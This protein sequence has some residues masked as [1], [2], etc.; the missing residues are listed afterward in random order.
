M[1]PNENRQFVKNIGSGVTSCQRI[2]KSR[3]I[4]KARFLINIEMVA[5]METIVIVFHGTQN[6]TDIVIVRVFFFFYFIPYLPHMFFRLYVLFQ[7]LVSLY[8]VIIIIITE[9]Q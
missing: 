6:I 3:A 1:I 8:T 5:A 9:L 2:L 4:E 7:V